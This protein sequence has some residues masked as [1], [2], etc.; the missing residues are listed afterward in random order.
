MV[1]HGTARHTGSV[2]HFGQRR[3]THPSLAKHA[4]RR[5]KQLLASLERFFFGTSS[6]L[7]SFEIVLKL[8]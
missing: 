2:R 3:M 5:V 4:L 8:H 7:M 1:I 6:H